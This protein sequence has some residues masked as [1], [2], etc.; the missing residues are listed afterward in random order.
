MNWYKKQIKVAVYN[1]KRSVPEDEKNTNPYLYEDSQSPESDFLD[2]QER[3]KQED[4]SSHV[5]DNERRFNNKA[6]VWD[7]E[8]VLTYIKERLKD[9]RLSREDKKGLR[10]EIK[11][12]ENS[13]SSTLRSTPR[14][15]TWIPYSNKSY[16][17]YDI[18]K[19]PDI[20]YYR[21]KDLYDR[22]KNN[23]L[24]RGWRPNRQE[25]VKKVS[26]MTSFPE[27]EVNYFLK[28]IEKK[29]R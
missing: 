1:T 13:I 2:E 29:K 5:K 11:N 19:G 15:E 6:K 28:K 25:F 23:T 3:R 22:F 16:T 21:I 18:P 10:R 7:K 24:F 8:E 14:S 12:L 20:A 4:A 27:N 26:E 17:S 9:P